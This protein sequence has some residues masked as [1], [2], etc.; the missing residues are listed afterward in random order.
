MGLNLS[1]LDILVPAAPCCVFYAA[2]HQIYW[3]SDMG[4]LVF[5]GTLIWYHTHG[6]THTG[7]IGTNRLTNT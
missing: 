6:Q 1:T 3:R 4:D 2:R 5:A 7:H